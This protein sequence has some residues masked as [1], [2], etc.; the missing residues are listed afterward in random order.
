MDEI[1]NSLNTKEWQLLL[2]LRELYGKLSDDEKNEKLGKWIEKKVK[3][4]D[5]RSGW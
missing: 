3:E 1:D 2:V 4:L 5:E